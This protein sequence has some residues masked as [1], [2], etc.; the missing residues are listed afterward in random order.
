MASPGLAVPEEPHQPLSFKFPKRQLV[1]QARP[2]LRNTDRFQYAARSAL[3]GK[4]LACETKR[5]YGQK[6]PV[7][8]SFKGHWF[9]QWSFLHYNQSACGQACKSNLTTQVLVA[10]AL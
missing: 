8:C 6:K 2:F 3:R 1:S 4:G 7:F 10:P 9:T 5:Q